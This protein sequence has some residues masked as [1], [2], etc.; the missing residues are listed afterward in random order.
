MLFSMKPFAALSGALFLFAS[1][2]IACGGSTAPV[3]A[4]AKPAPS[5]TASAS[6][7]AP[8][9]AHTAAPRVETPPP[10]PIVTIVTIVTQPATPPCRGV[11]LDLDQLLKDGQCGMPAPSAETPSAEGLQIALEVPAKITTNTT[12]TATLVM[13]N[14]HSTPL[15]FELEMGCGADAFAPKVYDAKGDRADL[16]TE[17]AFLSGCEQLTMR[18]TLEPQG[19]LTKKIPISMRSKILGTDCLSSRMKPLAKGTY[20]ATVDVPLWKKARP[21]S[22][23]CDVR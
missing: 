12:A 5:A 23:T 18:V 15:T 2:V 20:T 3:V 13:T 9:D 4:V 21:V 6:A 14:A 19:R 1:A 8:V 7:P 11:K 16:I 22:A 10:A 17:C